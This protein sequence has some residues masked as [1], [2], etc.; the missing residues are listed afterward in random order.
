MFVEGMRVRSVAV[1]G[2]GDGDCVLGLVCFCLET[3]SRFRMSFVYIFFE[4]YAFIVNFYSCTK[5]LIVV[6]VLC[7]DV[8]VGLCWSSGSHIYNQS[9]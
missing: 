6:V 9:Y 1:H 8:D 7:V 4:L 5:G 2:D 3:I